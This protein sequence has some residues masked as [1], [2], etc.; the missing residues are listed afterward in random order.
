LSRST[1]DAARIRYIEEQLQIGEIKSHGSFL[2]LKRHLGRPA[3]W[4]VANSQR[5]I[6]ILRVNIRPGSGKSGAS[7]KN[8]RIV[9]A[10]RAQ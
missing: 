3:Y 10:Q 9:E 7:L 5:Q 2:L 1:G 8:F 6:C 4:A